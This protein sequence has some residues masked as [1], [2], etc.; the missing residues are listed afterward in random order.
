MCTSAEQSSA[1]GGPTQGHR[2]ERRTCV[3]LWNEQQSPAMF[4]G[5][6]R[7]ERVDEEDIDGE[8]DKKKG[9]VCIYV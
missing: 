9:Y 1:E 7:G 4:T 2:R 6:I 5:V 3:E 8:E